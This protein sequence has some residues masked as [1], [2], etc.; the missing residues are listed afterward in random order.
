M[1]IVWRQSGPVN[2]GLLVS[3]CVF[4]LLISLRSPVYH[5]NAQQCCSA[6]VNSKPHPTLCLI[7]HEGSSGE[8]VQC[9]IICTL[10][11][12]VTGTLCC[13][14][15]LLLTLAGVK[16]PHKYLPYCITKIKVL[17]SCVLVL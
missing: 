13:T 12:D 15:M 17:V 3:V 7:V 2:I 5:S 8:N 16:G 6:S 10:S 1:D 4:Q 9:T 14:C 11:V